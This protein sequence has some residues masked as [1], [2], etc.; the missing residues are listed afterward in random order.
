MSSRSVYLAKY[1]HSANQ[2]THFALFIPNAPT[3]DRDSLTNLLLEAS[4]KGTIINVVGEPLLAGYVLEIKRNHEC[5]GEQDLR[6]LVFLSS[7]EASNIFTPTHDEYMAN[8]IPRGAVEREAARIAPPPKGQDIRAPIDGVKT[9][10]CQ[11]WTM[12]F[13]ERLVELKLIG[14]ES[15]VIAQEQRDPPTHGIF[16][17]GKQ[18]AGTA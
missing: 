11:E 13:L 7:V 3:T 8:D 1:R 17:L 6:D 5:R 9:R 14:P 16:G 15:L 2:R 18:S 4:C 12:S 10:R